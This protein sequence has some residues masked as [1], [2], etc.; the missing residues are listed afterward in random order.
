MYIPKRNS[1]PR[2]T[3]KSS[4]GLGRYSEIQPRNLEREEKKAETKSVS[5]MMEYED[6]LHAQYVEY[7][8]CNGS[9]G[10]TTENEV[11]G[12]METIASSADLG[13]DDKYDA[14]DALWTY[15][16]NNLEY[17]LASDV[18]QEISHTIDVVQHPDYYGDDK[19]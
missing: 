1:H 11:R 16:S 17:G 13:A 7:G 19:V 5:E 10:S 3:D 4:G 12:Y 9:P 8:I 2:R 14:L 6:G 18:L 15:A